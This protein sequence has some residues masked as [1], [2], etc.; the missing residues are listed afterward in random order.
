MLAAIYDGTDILNLEEYSLQKLAKS[1]VLV[2]VNYCGVCGTDR[3]IIKGEAPAKIPVILGH[4]YSGV[5]VDKAADIENVNV[6]D[7]VAVNPNIHCGYCKYCRKGL[8]NFCEN[9]QALGVT[10][11]GGFAEYSVVPASQIYK[12]PGN[13]DLSQVAFAEPISCC[14]RGVSQAEIKPGD[15]VVIVGGGSIG[16]IM[17]QLAKLSG[18]SKI[19]LIEPVELKRK[20]ASKYGADLSY[21]PTQKNLK[22]IIDDHTNGGPDVAIECVGKSESVELAV[23]LVDRGGRV[24][25][26]GLSNANKSVSL[27]LRKLFLKEI[28]IRNSFLNPFTFDAAVNLLVNGTI[29]V[30]GLISK[31]TPL[32]SINDIFNKDDHTFSI[33]TQLTNKT[34]RSNV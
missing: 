7:K 25:I 23:E 2:E 13:A 26:F 9:H 4:E 12:L 1:E 6:G 21:S 8:V 22:D 3:H 27:N 33:K 16:L 11:N 29:D 18:A 19:I 34:R 31:Q 32:Q 17:V 30:A 20:A 24:I 5:V 28:K 14:L 15:S 10:L